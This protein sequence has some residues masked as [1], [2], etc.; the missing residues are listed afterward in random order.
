MSGRERVFRWCWTG[1]KKGHDYGEVKSA[2]V[3]KK[4]IV[5]GGGE[6]SYCFCF[7]DDRGEGGGGT[8]LRLTLGLHQGKKR[9]HKVGKRGGS[10]VFVHF[11]EAGRLSTEGG[12]DAIGVA[13]CLHRAGFLEKGK[14]SYKGGERLP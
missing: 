3:K 1:K 4:K 6:H 5:K 7:R 11:F 2:A 12:R 10:S 8:P 9:N 13:A 14:A